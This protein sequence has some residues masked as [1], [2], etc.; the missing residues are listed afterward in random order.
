MLN[1]DQAPLPQLKSLAAQYA[2]L[3]KDLNDSLVNIQNN[4]FSCNYS[5]AIRAVEAQHILEDYNILN[6]PGLSD[7]KQVCATLN[8]TKPI[9]LAE[10]LADRINEL[11][12][13]QTPLFPFQKIHRRLSISRA[14]L[15]DRLKVLY[16]LDSLEPTNL[17]W[18][19]MITKLEA[20][21]DEE[22]RDEYNRICR[23]GESAEAINELYAELTNS[24]RKSS[25]PQDLFLKIKNKVNMFK[26]ENLMQSYRLMTKLLTKAYQEM[27][28][29]TAMEHL[30]TIQESLQKD[31][32]S[33]SALPEDVQKEVKTVLSWMK[34]MKKQ[35]AKQ[36][37]FQLQLARMQQ[38]LAENIETERLRRLYNSLTFASESVGVP[39]PESVTYAYQ[40][41]IRTEESQK[42]RALVFK[43]LLL[44]FT[45]LLVAGL[46]AFLIVHHNISSAANLLVDEINKEISVV[47]NGC[48]GKAADTA[49]Q[50][51]ASK[52]ISDKMKKKS[53][54]SEALTHLT[55]AA[56]ESDQK[57]K[58]YSEA[59]WA[60]S[61]SLD[62]LESKYNGLN[63]KVENEETDDEMRQRLLEL[64]SA[65][66]EHLEKSQD[67]LRTL[68]NNKTE[69][70]SES[71]ERLTARN[72]RLGKRISQ[73]YCRDKESPSVYRYILEDAEKEMRLDPSERKNVDNDLD[74]LSKIE[75]LQPLRKVVSEPFKNRHRTIRKKLDEE[76]KN[77]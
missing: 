40:K 14:P 17:S 21:R 73:L 6:F 61:E 74:C 15:R 39:I 37:E 22:L 30:T 33:L 56:K 11:Y 68:N 47:E 32:L 50:F 69:N 55:A 77:T 36:D 42:T 9:D 12:D 34:E 4:I 70:D 65:D 49:N 57:Y 31:G 58:A 13:T 51:I 54:V 25:P 52:N 19:E 18:S 59:E 23:E 46:A 1:P 7:W 53:N 75:G 35:V 63:E 24:R 27:D 60:L 29:P 26:R 71:F 41:R 72:E 16:K 62:T 20:K 10:D 43:I 48:G 3:C 64:V 2:G 76:K 66:R 45:C 28:Y 5:E 44:V 38:A 67:W 8:L